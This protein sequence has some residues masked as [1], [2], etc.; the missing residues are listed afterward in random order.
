MRK[1]VIFLFHLDLCSKANFHKVPVALV[2]YH[3]KQVD[4]LHSQ[5]P[6][7]FHSTWN[8][9]QKTPIKLAF[10]G[11][12]RKTKHFFFANYLKKKK[13]SST[14]YNSSMDKQSITKIFSPFN[15]L[16]NSASRTYFFI[17]INIISWSRML[18]IN[19]SCTGTSPYFLYNSTLMAWYRNTLCMASRT[20]SIPRKENEK[21]DTPPLTRAPGKF[22]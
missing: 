12:E 9:T 2:Q 18:S 13:C 15:L 16:Y 19:S 10:Y 21:L 1:P 17:T 7:P 6:C 8:L 5:F 14:V 22:S 20:A 11:G 4:T 3:H